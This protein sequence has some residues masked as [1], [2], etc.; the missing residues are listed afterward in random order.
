MARTSAFVD[1]VLDLLDPLEGVSARAMFGG[2][3]LFRDGVMFALI[4]DDTL[5]FKVDDGNRPDFKAACAS[6]FV[7]ERGGRR[8]ALSYYQVPAD[9]MEDPDD[10]CAW[11]REAFE[12]G[13]RARANGVERRA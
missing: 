13:L 3:G 5:Y 2:H 6:P 12:A 9:A 7:Y 4:A 11:A 1:Y 10:L 8:V